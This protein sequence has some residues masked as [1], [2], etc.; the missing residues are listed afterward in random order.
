MSKFALHEANKWFADIT[1]GAEGETSPVPKQPKSY[2]Y[3]NY[4]A[5]VRA[6]IGKYAADLGPTRAARHF[7]TLLKRDMSM[8]CYM[9]MYVVNRKH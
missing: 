8:C 2:M 1:E 9:Y 7:S 6:S 5:K 4:S 3:G